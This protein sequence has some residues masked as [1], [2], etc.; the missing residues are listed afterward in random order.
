MVRRHGKIKE[1]R[2]K[3]NEENKVLYA[4]KEIE[5]HFAFFRNIFFFPYLLNFIVLKK[6]FLIEILNDLLFFS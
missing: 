5:D 6:R 3:I 1:D 4:K 2:D